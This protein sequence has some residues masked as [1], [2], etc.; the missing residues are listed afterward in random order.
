MCVVKPASGLVS[1]RRNLIHAQEDTT[2]LTT[3]DLKRLEQE[4]MKRIGEVAKK[5]TQRISEM[6]M[7]LRWQNDQVLLS[8]QHQFFKPKTIKTF[9]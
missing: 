2:E 7:N 4:M 5:E 9:V 3:S 1:P 6:Q 8:I